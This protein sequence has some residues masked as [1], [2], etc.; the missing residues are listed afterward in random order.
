MFTS[1]SIHQNEIGDLDVTT[2]DGRIHLHYL[3]LPS[4]DSVGHAVSDDGLT[5]RPAPPA[6]RTGDPGDCDDDDIWTMHSVKNPRNGL[7][8]MYYT[9]LSLA[10]HGQFQ[11]VALATSRDFLTWKKH[12]DNPVLVPDAPAYT[13]DLEP[14]GRV[15]FRDPFCFIDE[16]G[17]WHLLVCAQ[18]GRGDRFRRGCVAHATSDDGVSWRLEKPLYAP[19]HLDDLEVPSLLRHGGRYYLFVKEFRGPRTFLRVADS[20]D[21]P[22]IAP[23]YDE[24][25]PPDN[26]VFRFCEWKGKTLCY[27]WYRC[28]ADWHRRCPAYASVLPPKEVHFSSDGALRMSSFSGWDACFKGEPRTFSPQDMVAY[29]E[30]PAEWTADESRLAAEVVGQVVC[31]ADCDEEDYI[32]ETT[33]RLDRGRAL[34]IFFRA[35]PDTEDANWLRLD[36]ERQR[37]E[38][39]RIGPM[40]TGFHR[41]VRCQPGL[42]QGFDT[43]LSL[44][45][46][47]DIRLIASREYIELSIDSRVVISSVTYARKSGRIG[48]FVENGAG[49][50]GPL[51][52]QPITP[53]ESGG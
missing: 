15:P 2:V 3:C 22:W 36:F 7:W 24:P 37:V 34:G 29:Q 30:G 39:V 6:L 27:T 18:E 48:V 4:H 50:F 23:P 20:L 13:A 44:E 35:T 11:R 1:P 9:A 31:A 40:E 41:Y 17:S 52:L 53:P 8:H 12:K 26:A 43:P 21:G 5:F 45:K 10:E 32:L 14:L 51:R 42:C 47:L 38:L 33:A 19:A 16:D 28:Q 49:I 46:D 25:M